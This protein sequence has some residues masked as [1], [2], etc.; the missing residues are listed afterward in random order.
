MTKSIAHPDIASVPSQV[1]VKTS[2]GGT[3]PYATNPGNGNPLI[4]NS[5]PDMPPAL[6]P[7]PSNVNNY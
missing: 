1:T 2:F 4:K 6:L 7:G 3:D 5:Q